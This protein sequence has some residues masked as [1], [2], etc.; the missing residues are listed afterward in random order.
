MI[1]IVAALTIV[2]AVAGT[3]TLAIVALNRFLDDRDV[4]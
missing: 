1:W 2:A 4:G 3:L